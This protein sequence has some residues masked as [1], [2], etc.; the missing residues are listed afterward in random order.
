VP[1]PCVTVNAQVGDTKCSHPGG[2]L[3]GGLDDSS[4]IQ[5]TE[6]GVIGDET[7][8]LVDW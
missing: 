3:Q 5:T 8:V 2:D 6:N 1:P 4:R 7:W